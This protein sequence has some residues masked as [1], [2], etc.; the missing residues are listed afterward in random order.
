MTVPRDTSRR[1]EGPRLGEARE[2]LNRVMERE[3]Q[4]RRSVRE[5]RLRQLDAQFVYPPSTDGAGQRRANS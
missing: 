1:Q 4:F 5:D 2:E 3:R